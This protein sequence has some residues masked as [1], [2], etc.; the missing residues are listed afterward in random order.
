MFRFEKIPEV[1]PA[2][3]HLL[4][5]LKAEIKHFSNIYFQFTSNKKTELIIIIIKIIILIKIIIKRKYFSFLFY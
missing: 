1:L 4:D 5:T 3:R 2:F